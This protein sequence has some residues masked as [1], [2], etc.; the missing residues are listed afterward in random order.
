MIG[1]R[2]SQTAATAGFGRVTVVA[3]LLGHAAF[4]GS[5]AATRGDEPPVRLT[6]IEAVQI[7][8]RVFACHGCRS[9]WC[10]ATRA[11]ANERRPRPAGPHEAGLPE[12]LITLRAPTQD[13]SC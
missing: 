12:S 3:T 4:L 11:G 10:R 8:E 6:P 9:R 13:G 1:H 5:A 2:A 7:H